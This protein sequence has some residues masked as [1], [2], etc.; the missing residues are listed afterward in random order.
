MA[1]LRTA[2]DASSWDLDVSSP[3]NLDGVAKSIPGDSVPLDGARAS[4][5]GR[6]QQLLVMKKGF[7]FGL[8]PSYAPTC[9][10]ELGSFALQT[11]LLRPTFPNGWLGLIGQFRP[12]KLI[13]SIK[14]DA[15]RIKDSGLPVF[16]DMAKRILDKSLY[17]LGLCSEVYPTDS[18]SIVLSTEGHGE[19]KKR[20][21]KATF[22]QQLPH[23]DISIEA[24]WPELFIDRNGGY[25]DMPGSISL[26][27]SSLASEPGLQYHF[28][29]HKNI[30]CPEAVN[31]AAASDQVPQALMSGVC[32]NAAIS[33]EKSHDFW[34]RNERN[35]D[36]V[37]KTEKGWFWRHSY[38]VRLR[39]PHS[40]ISGIIGGTFA[41]AFGGNEC[42]SPTRDADGTA[43]TSCKSSLNADLFGSVCYTFQHGQFRE[44]Y[45]DLTRL[46]A[47]IDVNSATALARRV[48]NFSQ[49]SPV[50]G[51]QNPLSSPRLNLIFQQQ[52]A[53]P[54]AFRVD[55]K[56][57]LNSSLQKP[58]PED[59]I[60]SLTYSLKLL[61]SGKV[62]AWYSPRRKEG[63]I[64]LRLFEF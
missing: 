23:H 48:L 29:L 15:A 38:D 41:A 57:A 54:L 12:K 56:F 25:W 47:R 16:K 14:A 20:R 43:I 34:R 24:A 33:Y 7:P 18:T 13:S 31:V 19:R 62:V 36:N 51:M 44:N 59:L 64:E 1:N 52:V 37:I 30:G 21:T 39:E 58:S 63:M 42:V 22:Y 45:G 49:S 27:L 26:N 10:K 28:G 55:T 40:A 32:V 17:S 60:Y 9:E 11:L 5:V 50:T 35:E 6:V 61:K 3:L 4:R 2:M 8:V 53:G 46:D